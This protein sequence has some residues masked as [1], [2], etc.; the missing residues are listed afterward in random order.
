MPRLLV[1]VLAILLACDLAGGRRITVRDG[2]N[3]PD[4]DA[5]AFLR[6]VH[7]AACRRFNVVLGPDANAFHRDHLHFDMGNGRYCR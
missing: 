7:A 3:G 5:R 4:A 6:Q 2:W 1:L